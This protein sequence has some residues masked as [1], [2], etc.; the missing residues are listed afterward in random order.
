MRHVVTSMGDSIVRSS[1]EKS[2]KAWFNDRNTGNLLRRL[3]YKRVGGYRVTT[4]ATAGQRSFTLNGVKDQIEMDA[5]Q[6]RDIPILILKLNPLGSWL[7]RYARDIFKLVRLLVD[8]L[9][10]G[11]ISMYAR[12]FRSSHI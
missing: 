3:L 12:P 2:G 5:C 6:T 4:C 9:N 7:R 10:I 1:E 8:I 11:G